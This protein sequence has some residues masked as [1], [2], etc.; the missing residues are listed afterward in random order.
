MPVS[1]NCK[2]VVKESDISFTTQVYKSAV[3]F[4]KFAI[5]IVILMDN[6]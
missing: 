3:Y 5:Q 1:V 4:V 6:E 2:S